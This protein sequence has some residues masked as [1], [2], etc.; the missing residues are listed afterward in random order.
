MCGRSAIVHVEPAWTRGPRR[1]SYQCLE[2]RSSVTPPPSLSSCWIFLHY[3]CYTAV[4]GISTILLLFLSLFSRFANF[5]P[6]PQGWFCGHLMETM[7]WPLRG[8][9]DT[10]YH[11]E[12]FPIGRT[13]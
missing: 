1:L 7:T 6:F 13:A 4:I 5:C 8:Y 9:P 10:S 12:R 11:L 3:A 2:K